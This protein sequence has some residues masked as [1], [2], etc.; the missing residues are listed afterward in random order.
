MRTAIKAGLVAAACTVVLAL[1]AAPASAVIT[2]VA[3]EG[4]NAPGPRQYDRV[5]VTKVGPRKADRVLVLV[6]GFIGGAGDLTL[7]ARDL[8]NR[9]PNLQVWA[10]DRRTQAF[11][12]TSVFERALGGEATGQEALDYYL[13]WIGDPSIQPHYEPLDEDGVPFVRRWG[14]EVAL[15]DLRH[16]VREAGRGSREVV[17]GGH[18]L[19]ASTT[20]AYASWD[21][22][23]RPGFRDLEGVVLI[24]GG[25]LGSFDAYNRTQA[26][27][28]LSELEQ[29][30]PFSDLLGLGLP[31]VA[32][33]FAEVGALFAKLDPTGASVLQQFPLL[34]QQFK[35]PVPAT[36]RGALGYAFDADTSPEALELIQVRA[37]QLAP[38]GDPRDWQDGE[39]T[40]IARVA[41]TFA[42]EPANGVE[43]YFP[44]RLRIDVNGADGLTR[45]RVANFL[46]LRLWHT[47]R[48]DVPLYAYQ[49][50][51]TDGDVL[52]GAERFVRRSSVRAKDAVLEDRTATTS[53]L[54][55]LTA[56]PRSNDFLKTVIP[57]LRDAF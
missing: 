27:Q 35:P 47:R 56:A 49:T 53:H 23:G 48:V 45:N 33:P 1:A 44:D 5:F 46:H 20:L 12:D 9:V 30:S 36:N 18:S 54:D 39:V 43:W 34:P 25:L 57:F 2:T 51:L 15:R 22:K 8:V 4:A 50:S 17:L 14:L 26:E 6:P 55:P 42:Q 38:S 16:V 52:R 40:P 24:D 37:G 13:G 41:D 10:V 7:V 31:W 29:G 32:G 28:A 3:I 21:F 11:E 19:G